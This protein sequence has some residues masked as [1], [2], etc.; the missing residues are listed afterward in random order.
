MNY[1][2]WKLKNYKQIDITNCYEHRESLKAMGFKWD[3][4]GK[5]WTRAFATAEELGDII[6]DVIINC[7]LTQSEAN[8]FIKKPFVGH[9]EN[10][11]PV[12]TPETA[13]RGYKYLKTAK[14]YPG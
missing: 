6:V 1:G 10:V 8:S 13:K 14:K 5:C 12:F 2:A 3:S 9:R 11:A 4:R 7:G